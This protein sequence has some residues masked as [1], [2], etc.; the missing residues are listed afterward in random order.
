M[1]SMSM[2]TMG[3][4]P[5]SLVMQKSKKVSVNSSESSLGF[6]FEHSQ[7]NKFFELYDEHAETVVFTSNLGKEESD[8]PAMITVNDT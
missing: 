1:T 6:D 7:P 2:L 3:K 5:L 8:M 4:K